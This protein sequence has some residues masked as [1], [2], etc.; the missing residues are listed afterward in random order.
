M[1]PPPCGEA[2]NVADRVAEMTKGKTSN[3]QINRVKFEDLSEDFLS[4]YR[5]NERKSLE[6]AEISVKRLKEWFGGMRAM[7]ITTDT[8][9][10]TS[11]IGRR[12]QQTAPSIG[13]WRP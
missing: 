10:S 4:D 8:I 5:V 9:R 7:D 12:S 3:I 2:L 13:S 11:S 1:R 6:R